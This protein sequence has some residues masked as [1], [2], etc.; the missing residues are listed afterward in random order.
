V[1]R[2]LYF[3]LILNP[4]ASAR[5][6]TLQGKPRGS[7]SLWKAGVC[8]AGAGLLAALDSDHSNNYR[9]S[10]GIGMGFTAGVVDAA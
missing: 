3:P 8:S 10:E 7:F 6:H 9:T 1:S 4:L 2:R 5:K